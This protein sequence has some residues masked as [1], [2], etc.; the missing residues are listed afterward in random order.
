MRRFLTWTLPIT[1]ALLATAAFAAGFLLY[2][3][4]HVGEA[5]GAAPVRSSDEPRKPVSI[6]ILG[7]SLARGLGDDTGLGI[8]G[9][10]LE[11]LRK[12]GSNIDQ[13]VNLSVNG[14]RTR[15]LLAQ[16][17]SRNVRALVA[18]ANTVIISIGGNDLRLYADRATGA[19]DGA[20]PPQ[21][22]EP[23]VVMTDVLQR[24]S[25]IVGRVRSANP[26]A[27]I[28]LLGLYNPFSKGPA[29]PLFDALVARWNGRLLEEFSADRNVTIVPIADLFS[30][31]NRL[32]LDAFHPSGE[33]YQL[34]A[35]R[36]ADAM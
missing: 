26:E 10:L 31:R 28:F 19:M 3:T 20:R 29:G 1:V 32:S 21:P 4:G 25:D 2:L 7:D 9:R 16:L 36:I 13:P 6:L 17:E 14:G 5:V 8:G 22:G 23:A 11:E 35:R 27:R 30:H 18:D 33:G 12:S 34:I 15:D 24:V